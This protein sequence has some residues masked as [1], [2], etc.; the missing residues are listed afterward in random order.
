M[1]VEP[2]RGRSLG[3]DSTEEHDLEEI[4]REIVESRALT[5]KTNNLVNALAADLKSI[6][7]RQQGAERRNVLTSATAY[8]I[9]VAVIL[10]LV[11][12]AWDYRVQATRETKQSSTGQV[13]ELRKKVDELERRQ[14]E[15]LAARRTAS[16]TYELVRRGELRAFLEAVPKLE[17]LT[18]TPTEKRVFDD[19]A[20][21]ARSDLSL[22]AYQTGLDHARTGRWHEAQVA[23]RE[24]LELDPNASHAPRANYQLARALR[25]LGQ[26]GEAMTILT[27]LTASSS[28]AEILD[29]ATFLLARAQVDVK[30][31]NEAKSTLRKFIARFPRSPYINE[32]RMTLAEIQL[33][34]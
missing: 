17:G 7:R 34:H 21:R 16:E 10:L 33:E 14:Q 31:W 15:E 11:K 28:D 29:D 5:I 26:H 9:T 4:K 27:R 3:P 30:L 32:A 19:A 22:T 6:A 25:R 20:A 13:E 1:R 23:L 18:L 24:S 2:P 8:A 12:V